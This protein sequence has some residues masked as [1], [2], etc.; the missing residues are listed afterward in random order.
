LM[1]VWL[2]RMSLPVVDFSEADS[3]PF[4]VRKDFRKLSFEL[5]HVD[6][7]TDLNIPVLLGVLRD[8]RNPDVFLT[9]MASSLR[10]NR[11]LEKLYKELIQFSYS[12][13]SRQVHHKN[14]MSD[15]MEPNSVMTFTDHLSFYQHRSKAHL[16]SFLTSSRT[17]KPISRWQHSIG[18]S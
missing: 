2:N 17:R 13:L 11:L 1:L 8:T 6:I 18:D 10:L 3:D 16:L 12:Y 5:N 14:A 9:T 15:C 7:T 4:G